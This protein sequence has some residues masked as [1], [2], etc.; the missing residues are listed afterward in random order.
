MV[1]AGFPFHENS[2]SINAEELTRM[3][4]A[5]SHAVQAFSVV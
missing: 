1:W 4:T 5:V 2:N 3:E